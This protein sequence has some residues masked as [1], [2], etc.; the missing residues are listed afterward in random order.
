MATGLGDMSGRAVVAG[1]H[2]GVVSVYR[3]CEL[4]VCETARLLAGV[5][6]LVRAGRDG[7]ARQLGWRTGRDAP[8]PGEVASLVE[9]NR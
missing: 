1:A 4:S 5:R 7:A 8:S 9:R 3:A 6:G 2:G